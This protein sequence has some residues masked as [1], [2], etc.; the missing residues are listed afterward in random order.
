MRF[1]AIEIKN[2]R[3]YK[4]LRIS[5]NKNE[6]TD[7]HIII[8]ENGI[9]KTNLLNAINWCLYDDEPHMAK[10]N[11]GLPK[12]NI[13]TI[14]ES[15][16]NGEKQARIEV[17]LYTED[18]GIDINYRRSLD[19]RIKSKNEAVE[20]CNTDSFVVIVNRPGFD[21]EIIKQEEAKAWVQ[22][23][24]PTKIRKYF[25][26]DGEQLHNYFESTE[27]FKLKEAIHNIS[28]VDLIDRVV[29]RLQKLNIEKKREA[30]NSIPDIG[31]I[32]DQIDLEVKTN[33]ENEEIAR[34]LKIEINK[35]ENR[36]NEI[37]LLLRGDDDIGELE[38]KRNQLE[39]TLKLCKEEKKLLDKELKKFILD[40]R[41]ILSFYPKVKQTLEMIKEKEEKEDL[42]PNVDKELLKSM[43]EEHKCKICQKPLS[44]M[45]EKNIIALLDSIT[46]SSSV[47]KIL[48]EN[49][50]ELQHIINEAHEY[51][52]KR[53]SLIKRDKSITERINNLGSELQKIDNKLAGSNVERIKELYKEREMLKA[54]NVNNL[55]RL[56]VLEEKNN[57]SKSKIEEL[58]IQYNKA[59]KEKN[60]N[61]QLQKEIEFLK[62]SLDI[63]ISIG[64]ELM[65]EVKDK[66]QK[67]TTEL[68]KKLIW[69]KNTYSH[70]ELDNE[71]NLDLKHIAGYSAVGS[72]S[73]GEKALLALSFTLALHEISGFNNLL[74]ID[75]PVARLSGDNRSNFAN[76]LKEASKNKQ[77]I[78]SFTPN[79][80]S[81]EVSNVF[82]GNLASENH[83]KTNNELFTVL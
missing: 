28:Q 45:D 3:Q 42:P 64:K 26:F 69:K 75:T 12:I 55:K 78:M 22:K 61:K 48:V 44:K 68:F 43:I 4:S 65:S 60:K 80:Y 74:F 30:N 63:T 77:I 58:N 19:C 41:I 53:D 31:K 37:S 40:Y 32:Q 76:V 17:V 29:D 5:F 7:L 20:L 18:D 51:K 82:D 81:R 13:N 25:F 83:L 6:Y 47:A 2:Y 16:L 72:C 11:A 54:G 46:L 66:M 14:E 62:E 24:M 73:A 27:N 9:G 59:L 23:Y 34:K 33:N 10:Q 52:S 8:A 15:Y 56:G 71:Y 38:N 79:E 36:I 70:I 49:K 21:S 39:N 1:K 35:A 57:T 67:R 50:N